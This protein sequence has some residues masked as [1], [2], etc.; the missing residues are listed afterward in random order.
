MAILTKLFTAILAVGIAFSA[1]VHAGLVNDVPSCYAAYNIKFQPAAPDKLI[2]VLIDQTVELDPTLKQSVISNF[3]RMLGPKTKFVVAEFSA[4]SQGRYLKV[5]NTGII[6]APLT[7]DEANDVPIR[8]LRSFRACLTEQAKFAVA[9]A[10]KAVKKALDGA[11]SS[12]GRSD[13]MFTLRNVS[14]AI[15]ADPAEKKVLFLVTD[16]LENSSVTSFYANNTVRRIDPAV[17]LD[18]A[19]S[20]NLFG[21]F[22]GAKVFVLGGGML[23]PAKKGTKDARNGYRDPI[24]LNRLKEFWEGYF[25]NSNADLVEFGQPALL[26]PLHY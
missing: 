15:K 12:L 18:K 7:Q 26:K 10:K 2:Y 20:A 4:F 24:T 8:K 5:L 3:T 19:K 17:E 14:S 1:S 23:Q 21:D 16:G 11:T 6:E 13:I 9:L 22:G 25:K